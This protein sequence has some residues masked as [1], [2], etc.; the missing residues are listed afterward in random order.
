MYLAKMQRFGVQPNGSQV[1][2]LA[3]PVATSNNGCSVC[4][5]LDSAG[6][7]AETDDDD[8]SSIDTATRLS[9]ALP[10]AANY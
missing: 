7:A 4:H 8:D 2:V 3:T 1:S 5:R 10:R 9:Q 6:S